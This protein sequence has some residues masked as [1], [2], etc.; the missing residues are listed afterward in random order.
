MEHFYF[1]NCIYE[2]LYKD[3]ARAEAVPTS[4]ILHT[5][6][7]D[8]RVVLVGDALM[9]PEELF[10]PYGSIYYYSNTETPGILWLKRIAEQPDDLWFL[11]VQFHPEFNSMFLATHSLFRDFVRASVESGRSRA[12]RRACGEGR[13]RSGRA[14]WTPPP[15]SRR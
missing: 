7:S 2:S 6:E 14:E 13:S 4:Q 12:G 8:Y 10:S 11:A 5:L 1:H 3:M 15:G 9:A